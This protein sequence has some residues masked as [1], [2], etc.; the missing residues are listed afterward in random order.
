M[1]ISVTEAYIDAEN[2]ND[3]I[4]DK[5]PAY[6]TSCNP[7]YLFT[8]DNPEDILSNMNLNGKLI[9]V[10]GSFDHQLNAIL[11]GAKNITS[12]DI[13]NIAKY[14]AELKLQA[15]KHLSYEEF[16]DFYKIRKR[17]GKKFKCD[18]IFNNLDKNVVYK[19]CNDMDYSLLFD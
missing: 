18:A 3:K 9:S 8:N 2:F 1:G 10:T 16:M 15:I 13:N 6:F 12:F 7:V 19:L 5:N 17:I 11:M 4:C 14:F